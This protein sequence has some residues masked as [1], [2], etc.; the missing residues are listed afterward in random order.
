MPSTPS[1]SGKTQP[2]PRRD[3][4]AE[5]AAESQQHAEAVD[6]DFECDAPRF[7]DFVAAGLTSS[8]PVRAG[9]VDGWFGAPPGYLTL[10]VYPDS[11]YCA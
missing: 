1:S 4:L 2:S 8:S 7:Y 11:I 9:A 3:L 10:G 6:P 5:L